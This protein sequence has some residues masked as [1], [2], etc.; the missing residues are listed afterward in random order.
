M[1]V[2]PLVAAAGRGDRSGRP[3]PERRHR[4]AAHRDLRRALRG[5]R[6]PQPARH[7]RRL[8]RGVRRRPPRPAGPPRRGD[9][10]LHRPG[11]G[12][13][14]AVHPGP[15]S[16]RRG[17]CL[18]LGRPRSSASRLW[19]FLA[20]RLG[21]DRR[22]ARLPGRRRGL[23]SA[24]HAGH[25]VVGRAA[26]LARPRGRLVGGTALVRRPRR[27]WPARLE[28]L[29]GAAGPASAAPPWP[30]RLVW[31]AL[32]RREVA[33]PAGPPCAGARTPPATT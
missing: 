20:P 8:G 16:P 2:P 17:A 31:L 14:A 12:D 10:H 6:H 13:D 33:R 30:S 5:P 18:N 32:T 1:L 11:R 3:R 9:A 22:R 28:G 7:R 27:R 25:R 26:P 29:G 24:R 4:A 15:R 21:I 19:P 23:A